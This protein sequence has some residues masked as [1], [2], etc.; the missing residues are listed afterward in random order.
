MIWLNIKK[1]VRVWYD[2]NIRDR[3]EPLLRKI[4]FT[5]IV[6]MDPTDWENVKFN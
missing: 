4:G 3:L 5:Y 6:D 1:E 2:N